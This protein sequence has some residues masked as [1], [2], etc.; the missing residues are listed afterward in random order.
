M[1][2]LVRVIPLSV[3]LSDSSYLLLS[4]MRYGHED[5]QP[6]ASY[7]VCTC[8]WWHCIVCIYVCGIVLKPRY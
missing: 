2:I 1:V 5:S 8:K 7:F 4:P 6:G 3:S